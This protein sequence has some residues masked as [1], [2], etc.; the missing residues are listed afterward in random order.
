MRAKVAAQE[1][2]RAV[3]S[4]KI[5]IEM[6]FA[7]EIKFRRSERAAFPLEKLF[8]SLE[9]FYHFYP[10]PLLQLLAR[11]FAYLLVKRYVLDSR[12]GRVFWKWLACLNFSSDL[13]IS[14]LATSCQRTFPFDSE[15]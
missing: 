10:Y 12:G 15:T 14:P 3:C 9:G 4:P 11:D 8:G 2:L 7:R 5:R 1:G 13:T 6:R